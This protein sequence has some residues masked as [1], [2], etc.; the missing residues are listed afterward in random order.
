LSLQ[1]GGEH[2]ARDRNEKQLAG[3]SGALEVEMTRKAFHEAPTI[4]AERLVLRAYQIEDF[5]HMAAAWA[6]PDVVRY[7]GG[8]PSTE[9]ESWTRFLRNIALWP[10]LGYG[11]WAA[12]EKATGRYV[13]DVGFADFKRE[14]EP[15]LKGVPEVGWVLARESHGRGY[16][17]E[18]AQAALRWLEGALGPQRTVCII[19]DENRASVRVAEKCGYRELTRTQYKGSTVVMLE[20]P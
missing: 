4:E 9:E 13:G 19:D 16:A 20:R 1:A 6:D 3:P 11:Y 17:T 14:I 18:A 5:P 8:R 10:M 15:S 7:V 12:T 2:D